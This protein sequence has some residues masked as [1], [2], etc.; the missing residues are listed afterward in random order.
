[1]K[2][3]LSIILLGVI[4]S[5][6]TTANQ[7][8]NAL[9]DYVCID[10]PDCHNRNILTMPAQPITFPLDK[11]MLQAL[12]H[13]QRKYD[14]EQ[15]IAGLAAPQ[16]GYAYQIIIFAVNDDPFLRK[17]RNDLTDTMPRTIWF[18]PN[19]TGVGAKDSE[20]IEGCF[21]I[22]NH[23]G[24][25]KRYK[26]IRY[27]AISTDGSKITGEA[28]GFLARVIQHEVDHIHGILCLDSLSDDEKI[29]KQEYIKIRQQQ[30]MKNKE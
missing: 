8:V 1:M 19:Y 14:N 3:L 5:A 18:N 27:E 2:N 20:D 7:I 15:N 4:M 11:N 28:S 17:I 26:H 12:D 21:S 25:V 24:Q 13:I 29:D 16:I 6:C 23:V 9:P 30:L 22:K 10:D